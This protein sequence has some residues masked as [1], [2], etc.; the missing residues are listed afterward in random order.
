MA[1]TDRVLFLSLKPLYAELV[2]DGAKTV[3]LRRV[4]PRAEAGTLAIVY[5]TTPVQAVV[6]TCVVDDIGTETPDTIWDLHGPSTGIQRDQFDTYFRGRDVAVAITVSRPRRIERPVSLSA[7]RQGLD[8][9]YPPQSFRYLTP[10]QAAT[11]VPH[12][13]ASHLHSQHVIARI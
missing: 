6:G 7:L 10:T 9:F 13:W 5:S 11:L 4:R 8:H 1:P 3:E 12:E 2:L